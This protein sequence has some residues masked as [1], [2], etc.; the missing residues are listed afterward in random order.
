MSCCFVLISILTFIPPFTRIPPTVTSHT[1]AKGH[2]RS[3]RSVA[4]ADRPNAGET[5][6][7][8]RVRCVCAMCLCVRARCVC[9]VCVFNDACYYYNYFIRTYTDTHFHSHTHTC[10]HIRTHIHTCHRLS[11][12]VIELLKQYDMRTLYKRVGQV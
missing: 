1:H 10:T 11:P 4:V 12:Q 3:G 5:G 2:A 8:V 9:N 6:N 7:C